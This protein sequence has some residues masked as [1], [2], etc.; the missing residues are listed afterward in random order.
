M[1]KRM[2]NGVK[3]WTESTD[4]R[5]SPPSQPRL[6]SSGLVTRARWGGFLLAAALAVSG[7]SGPSKPSPPPPPPLEPIIAC[8]EPQTLQSPDDQPLNVVYGSPTVQNGKPP[9]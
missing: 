4:T 3:E 5:A 8:P 9:V 2:C 6:Y 7:C 1:T